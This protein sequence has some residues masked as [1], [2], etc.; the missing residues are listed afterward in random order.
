MYIELF[1]ANNIFLS[2]I[3]LQETWLS[4]QCDD[5]LLQ[6]DDYN[7]ITKGKSCSA[8]GGVAVY[9]NKCFNYTIIEHKESNLWDGIFVRVME[10][11]DSIIKRNII[12]GNIYRPP[13][14]NCEI[15][16][17]FSEE[18]L[19]LFQ[20]FQNYKHVTMAGDFNLDLLKIKENQQI[21]S[22]FESILSHGY[23]PK[24]TLPTRLTDTNGTL[25]DNILVKISD[26]FPES[27]VGILLQHI[28]DHLPCFIA[29]DHSQKQAQT[30][31]YIKITTKTNQG[32]TNFKQYL[33]NIKFTD[34]L[35]YSLDTNPNTNYDILN[36]IL[37]KGITE[38]FPIKIVRFNKHK[39][40][41]CPWITQ[42]ILI[43]M[44]YRDSLYKQLKSTPVHESQYWIK[45][46]NLRVYCRILKKSI[47]H[48]KLKYYSQCFQKFKND[49]R[50]T[51]ITIKSIINKMGDKKEI[52]NHIMING[53]KVCDKIT[54]ANQFNQFFVDIGPKYSE[55]I[56]IPPDSNFNDYLRYQESTSFQFTSITPEQVVKIIENLKSKSSYGVDR[57]SNRL[58]KQIKY[59]LS[60]PIAVIINQS[61]SQGIFPDKLKIAK[62]IPLFKSGDSHVLNNYRPVSVLPSISKIFEK[63]MF[64]Q[65]YEYFHE[66]NL[67]YQSQ[68]GFRS[69]H[70]TELAA[71]EFI[72]RITM[73]M[74]KGKVP[75]S[76]F[77]DFSK[78]FDTIDHKILLSKLEFY[79]MKEK[80][81]N[82]IQNYFTNRFQ[83]V[84]FDDVESD[85]LLITTGVPQGSI[86]GPLFFIIYV[87][88]LSTVSS[89][90]HTIMYAD[91]TTLISTINTMNT[92]T[93]TSNYINKELEKFDLWLRVNK[94]TLNCN[95]SKAMIFH[96][97]QKR[98]VYPDIIMNNTQIEYVN[99]FNY[100][101]IHISKDLG[102]NMHTDIIT[103]KISKVA[104][105]LNRLRHFL[106]QSVLLNIYNSLIVPHL[107]YGSLLWEKY[108]YKLF[109]NQKYA[110]RSITSSKYNAHTGPLF[111]KLGLLK[112]KDICALH[113]F[114][115]CYKL[116]N[117]LLPVYFHS[118]IFQKRRQIH[119]YYSRYN[120]MYIL[121]IIKHDYA[122]Q[123][124][125]Y[126]IPKLFNSMEP[127]IREKIYSHGIIGFK[128]FVKKFLIQSYDNDC[129][130]DDCFVCNDI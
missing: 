129:S 106:P 68:Y 77:L 71:I 83:Y 110:I 31:K 44:K 15:I 17:S 80:S 48:A 62:V 59:E 12:I 35:D 36:Q 34:K 30:P 46:E 116:E 124:I 76:I 21:N 66:N 107:N 82:L 28:S 92:S 97:P 8:H 67:L 78:A 69:N 10:N 37:M 64:N 85:P 108:S 103:K 123:S 42:G 93:N 60:E 25:I 70:S 94:L 74:D 20:Q 130:V 33:Q 111:K 87:N 73:E 113:G 38:C 52:P 55:N 41:K 65:I 13:Q 84:Q 26:K 19:Q 7:L 23:L 126:K 43:S 115:F 109:K 1:K 117:E 5:S 63:F 104:G 112:C 102:W 51:W 40:R 128:L 11:S 127:S 96:L 53:K 45:K 98:L 14:Q 6:L 54:I 47:R 39:H 32:I 58:L 89:H 75:L 2:A 105:I 18:M 27:T 122:R 50:N 22:Y 81:L 57:I 125:T 49:A 4:E 72:N 56:E 91:D 90:F 24:I 114:K 3:C 16:K 61:I 9:L 99:S 101:G 120:N 29:F 95:K 79:G 86:L 119:E 100:L 118:G 121:P 88:D